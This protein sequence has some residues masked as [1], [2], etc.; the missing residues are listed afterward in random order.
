MKKLLIYPMLFICY[1]AYG[2]DQAK[3]DTIFSLKYN[4]DRIENSKM[5][6]LTNGLISKCKTKH[7]DFDRTLNLEYNLD[8][9]VLSTLKEFERFTKSNIFGDYKYFIYSYFCSDCDFLDEICLIEFHYTQKSKVEIFKRKI[10]KIIN[11]KE[12][13]NYPQ[14]KLFY[15]KIFDNN[16]CYL[17]ISIKNNA[18]NDIFWELKKRIEKLE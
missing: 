11:D 9:S 18:N 8:Y 3:T 16:V 5:N 7:L 15:Y 1:I 10:E 14:D 4:Y 17:L 6:M 12:F 13:Y 2:Q